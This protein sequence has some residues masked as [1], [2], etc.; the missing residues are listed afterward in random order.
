MIS[1]NTDEVVSDSDY[2]LIEAFCLALI[3][4]DLY[5]MNEVLYLVNEKMSSECSCLEE[6]CVCGKW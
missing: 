1:L 4:K 2:E 3:D 5:S 6:D